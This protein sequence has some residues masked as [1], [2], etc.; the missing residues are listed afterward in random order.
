MTFQPIIIVVVVVNVVVVVVVNVVIVF[1]VP[2]I[3]AIIKSQQK[4]WNQHRKKINGIYIEMCLEISDVSY[5]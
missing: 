5:S 2:V 1:V 3:V 4:I